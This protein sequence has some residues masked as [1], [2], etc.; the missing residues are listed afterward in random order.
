MRLGT[1]TGSLIN[2]VLTHNVAHAMPKVGDGATLYSWSDRHAATVIA[3]EKNIVTVQADTAKRTD[4]NGMFEMQEY[5]FT[6]NPNGYKQTFKQGPR[7]DFYE[8]TKNPETGR[9]V[10]TGGKGISFGHRR[11]YHDYSF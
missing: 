11:A 9:W 5:E 10:K 3:V 6:P 8:V 2:H 1:Q 4:S 7:G